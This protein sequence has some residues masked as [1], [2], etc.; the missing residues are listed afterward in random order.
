M[1]EAHQ[2]GG[3]RPAG[4]TVCTDP[5]NLISGN[6]NQA[7]GQASTV[8]GNFIGTNLAGTAA[9][10]NG[11]SGPQGAA[12]LDADQLGGQSNAVALGVCDQACNLISGNNGVGVGIGSIRGVRTS[13]AI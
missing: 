9:I 5:C 3:D 8:E 10:P 7:V 1:A 6:L 11:T 2:V 12:V 4:S 13:R